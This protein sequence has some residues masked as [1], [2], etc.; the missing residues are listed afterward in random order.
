MKEK[1]LRLVTSEQ[2]KRLKEIAKK[3]N[4]LEYRRNIPEEYHPVLVENNLCIV[5]GGS[6]DLCYFIYPENGNVSSEELPCWGGEIFW[7]DKD[8]KKFLNGRKKTMLTYHD[9]VQADC[10]NRIEA[11]WCYERT[12][13]PDGNVYSWTYKT[14]I[15]HVTFDIMEDDMYY[16]KA[17]IFNINYLK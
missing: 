4:G 6:D 8:F 15:P 2:E 10:N 17:I 13:V 9:D 14:D 5:L 1:Q 3:L 12:K 7:F 16:C 11:V